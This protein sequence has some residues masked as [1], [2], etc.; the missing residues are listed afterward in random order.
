ME[1]PPTAVPADSP[2]KGLSINHQAS[3]SLYSSEAERHR[4]APA[5]GCFLNYGCGAI[6]GAGQASPSRVHSLAGTGRGDSIEPTVQRA[7]GERQ[8]AW[9]LASPAGGLALGSCGPETVSGFLVQTRP[10]P[11]QSRG[12]GVSQHLHSLTLR[13]RWEGAARWGPQKQRL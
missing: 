5:A 12:T 4:R 11:R 13:R 8:P 2:R 3:R 10:R 7:P 1:R 6:A 9:W